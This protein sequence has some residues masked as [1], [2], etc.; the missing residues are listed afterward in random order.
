[1]YQSN[2]LY[3]SAQEFSAGAVIGAF[4]STIFYPMNVVKVQMQSSCGG[5]Y[6]NFSQVLRH[7]YRERGHKFKNIYKGVSIN[8]WRAFFSWGIMNTAYEQIKNV[9]FWGGGHVKW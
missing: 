9:M 6:E 5:P 7:I 4:I 3:Q 8:G 2:Q 1:M